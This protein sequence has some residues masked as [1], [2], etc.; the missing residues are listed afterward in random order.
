MTQ[1]INKELVIVGAGPAGLAAAIRAVE[2]GARVCVI[3][4]AP[5][6]GGQIYRQ[7]PAA[8]RVPSG[9]AGDKDKLRGE[10]LL[11]RFRELPA[12]IEFMGGTAVLGLFE[13]KT[14][15]LFRAGRT[16]EIQAEAL[17]LATGAWERSVPCPGWTLPGVFTVGGC[18]IMLKSQHILPGRRVLVAGTGPLLLVLANQ[19]A[20]AGAQVV[21]VLE[22]SSLT[23]LALA[24]Q[25]LWGH[26]G[27]LAEGLGHLR[28]L[29]RAGIPFLQRHTILAARGEGQVSEAVIGRLD[30]NWAPVPG[31]ERSLEVDALAVGF[32]FVP[33]T[34]LTRM[35][36]C[37]HRFDAELGGW[38]PERGQ[39]METTQPGIFA[40]G[41]GAGVAGAVV[42]EIEGR[43]AALGVLERLGK[44]NGETAQAEARGPQRELRKLAR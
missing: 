28:A 21:A 6:P 20:R 42:A 13:H 27:L 43:L 17:I 35:A 44:L 37:A 33:N 2:G 31:S 26:W 19:L 11:S 15:A 9:A 22:A 40:A 24:P 39:H 32:G 38:V 41:D 23:G 30:R 29:R 12:G 25:L 7:P 34:E 8:F 1:P 3:D 16:L 14:L 4:E 18:Q 5:A 36:L 10:A